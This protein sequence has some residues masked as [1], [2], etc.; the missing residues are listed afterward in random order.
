MCVIIISPE[1]ITI[2]VPKEYWKGI[3]IVVP[4]VMSVYFMFLYSL[5]VNIEYFFKKTNYIAIGTIFAAVLN[6]LLNSYFIPKFGYEAAAY[7]TL[8]SY[9][10]LFIFHWI[11]CKKIFNRKLY[12][13]KLLMLSTLAVSL[14]AI[15]IMILKDNLV[16]RYGILIIVV[17]LVIANYKKFTRIF[18]SFK[19][20]S[21]NKT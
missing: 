1:I 6:I 3:N 8:I 18:S 2:M 7:T 14:F 20:N 5:P 17:L 15:A 13:I 16:I 12:D 19:I 11:I 10:C 9:I 21:V 4:L